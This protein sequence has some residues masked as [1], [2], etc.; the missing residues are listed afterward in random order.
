MENKIWHTPDEKPEIRKT[1]IFYDKFNHFLHKGEYLGEYFYSDL[2]TD[3]E[4]CY[5]PRDVIEWAYLEKVLSTSKAL[6]VAMDALG[7]VKMSDVPMWHY[8]ADKIE[9]INAIMNNEGKE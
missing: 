1:I 3:N 8:A 5:N 7:H 4:T 2:D 6:D 9:E